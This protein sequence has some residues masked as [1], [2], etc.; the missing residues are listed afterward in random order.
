MKLQYPIRSLSYTVSDDE[1]F[2]EKWKTF[3]L[4]THTFSHN[5]YL[6][7]TVRS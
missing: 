2:E 7:Y 6:S 3:K 4:S 5:N 1:I